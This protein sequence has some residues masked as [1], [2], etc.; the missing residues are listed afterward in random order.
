MISAQSL[1]GR[2]LGRSSAAPGMP[3]QIL[4]FGE[5]YRPVPIEKFVYGF[6]QGERMNDFAFDSILNKKLLRQR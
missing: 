3:A 2:W 5:E 4:Q 6:A 1:I